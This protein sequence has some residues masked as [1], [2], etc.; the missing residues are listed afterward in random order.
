M[1]KVALILV[2]I[3]NLGIAQS[4]Q[5]NY[6]ISDSLANAPNFK[7]THFPIH[8]K[9]SH[10]TSKEIINYAGLK[11]DSL[12]NFTNTY[13]NR[14]SNLVSPIL[15]SI[16][17]YFGFENTSN[18]VDT[19]IL[20]LI[21]PNTSNYFSNT[22]FRKDTF[23]LDSSNSSTNFRTN[24]QK[25]TWNINESITDEVVLIQ[26]E[27]LGPSVDSFALIT[28]Y[29]YQPVST[30][31]FDQAINS[32]FGLNSFGYFYSFSI[33]LPT[34]TGSNLFFDCN[35]NLLSDS[36]DGKSYI[37]NWN[38]TS[39]ISSP[40]IGISENDFDKIIVYPNPASNK[41]YISGVKSSCNFEIFDLWGRVILHGEVINEIDI[42]GIEQGI[43][44]LRINDKN[45]TYDKKIWVVD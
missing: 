16:D 29:G 21:S 41:L 30:C 4:L 42:A 14:F 35:G 11:V 9:N 39:Y 7:S 18:L 45:R 2:F 22:S 20:S 25:I 1:S 3:F 37:Q 19:L 26:I 6:Y 15:D 10:L 23:Y 13:S 33:L 32:T 28:G 40:S 5:L 27:F 17:I 38:I 12:T 31:S 34:E 24:K 44:I 8:Q 36:T 43:Y